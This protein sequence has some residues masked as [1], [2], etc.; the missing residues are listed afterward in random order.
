MPHGHM[1]TNDISGVHVQ[2]EQYVIIL[3]QLMVRYMTRPLQ[4]ILI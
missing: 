1:E 4:E 3:K 2:N